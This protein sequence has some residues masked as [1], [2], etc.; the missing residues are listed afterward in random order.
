MSV[1]IERSASSPACVAH[2]HGDVD[3]AA[4]PEIRAAVE[5]AVVSGCT[6][7]VLDLS[8]VEY[9]DSSA[10]GL[11]VWMDRRLR[12]CGGKVVLVAPDRNVSRIIELSGLVGVAPS[13]STAADLEEALGSLEMPPLCSE[14]L[15]ERTLTASA[16]ADEMTRLRSRVCEVVSP[17]GLSESAAFDLKVAVGEALANAVR[18]GSSSGEDEVSATVAAYHDRVIVSVRDSGEGF[19]GDTTSGEDVYASGGRGVMFMH[20]LTDAVEFTCSESGGTVVRLTK[21]LSAPHAES[22]AP[23]DRG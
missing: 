3:I 19:N 5:S 14:V 6:H 20:A 2:L 7:V 15:W 13:L 1:T 18:H 23:G 8:G 22:E 4:V 12:P 11:L 21:R 16:R 17:L 10:L 9:A